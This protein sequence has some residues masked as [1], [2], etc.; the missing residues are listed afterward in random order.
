MRLFA[1]L[2]ALAAGLNILLGAHEWAGVLAGSLN[3]PDSYMRLLR[4]EQ[5]L[6]AGRLVTVV[7]RDDS[8]AGVMVEWSR[9]LDMLLVAMAAPMAV[10][11]GWHRALYAAGVALGPLSVGALGAVLAWVIEPFAA[12]GYLWTAAFAAASLPGILTF[13]VPGVVHYHIL[14]LVLIALT[15]GYSLRAWRGDVGQG[16]LAGISGGF[17]IWLTPE[18]MPFVLMA[19]AALLIRWLSTRLG[20]TMTACA[21]GFFDVLGFA[22]VIDPPHGGYGVAEIDRLSLVYVLLGFLL[23]AG[24]GAL[25]WLEVRK[26]RYARALGLGLMAILM[27]GWVALFP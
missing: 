15:V 3:D 24:C 14:L 10:F 1:L 7:A 22:L 23:L 27:L 4:I 11:I 26:L 9:L 12:R 19:F 21:A 18:T 17:A 5:G 25:W 6:H 8:G 16:F 20:S 13:A 2:F